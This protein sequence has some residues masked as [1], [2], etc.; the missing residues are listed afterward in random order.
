MQE[1]LFDYFYNNYL[2]I[3]IIFKKSAITCMYVRVH[4]LWLKAFV[5]IQ[6]KKTC[7]THEFC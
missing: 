4:I 2:K 6:Q 3:T 7:D 1:M 5:D